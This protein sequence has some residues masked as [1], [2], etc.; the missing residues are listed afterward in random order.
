MVQHGTVPVTEQEPL[1]ATGTVPIL[2]PTYDT[3]LPLPPY[4]IRSELE[5]ANWSIGQYAKGVITLVFG[6]QFKTI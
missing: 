4:P 2:I 1:Y 3:V 5:R 6:K